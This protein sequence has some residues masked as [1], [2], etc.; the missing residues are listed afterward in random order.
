MEW[1]LIFLA[2]LLM[3]MSGN[4]NRRL[5]RLERKI[6]LLLDRIDVDG[7]EI[8][9]EI[10]RLEQKST[11]KMKALRQNRIQGLI[12]STLIGGALGYPVGVLLSP[13]LGLYS[14][15]LFGVILWVP[16]G[17]TLG[18]IVGFFL[19]RKVGYQSAERIE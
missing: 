12:G 1:Y 4:S 13:L 8:D 6:E 18:L 19:S 2:I 9:A 15:G 7:E 10:Q 3:S 16:I 14:G 5:D 17:M 11:A